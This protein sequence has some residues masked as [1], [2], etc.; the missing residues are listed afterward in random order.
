MKKAHDAA[1]QQLAL[2][3]FE[4]AKKAAAL[5][6]KLAKDKVKAE[7]LKE[8]IA[9]AEAAGVK[10]QAAAKKAEIARG[11]TADRAKLVANEQ[12]QADGKA[13][14]LDIAKKHKNAAANAVA[15][16]VMTKDQAQ[17]F[18][19]EYAAAEK[20]AKE[21]ILARDKAAK[22]HKTATA[23][24]ASADK[25]A[26]EAQAAH[27]AAK[28]AVNGM[29]TTSPPKLAPKSGAAGQGSGNTSSPTR[30][31][32]PTDYLL[33]EGRPGML[34]G[35]GSNACFGVTCC[36]SKHIC[37]WQRTGKALWQGKMTCWSGKNLVSFERKGVWFP[38]AWIPVT[39]GG[40]VLVGG[41]VA[42]WNYFSQGA[43]N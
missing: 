36:N 31:C 16:G 28:A 40:V 35:N 2:K 6:A 23:A 5:K 8:K 34:E 10:A 33:W 17:K 11:L 30:K 24:Q 22:A 3:E 12:K 19:Q 29:K 21:A 43:V 7:A 39:L 32:V 13:R 9:T 20:A 42:L 37:K 38:F 1:R 15:A 14:L 4:E 25:Q 26:A 41:A 18:E 27:D